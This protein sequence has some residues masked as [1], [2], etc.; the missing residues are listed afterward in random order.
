[1]NEISIELD[2]QEFAG[3]ETIAGAVIVRLDQDTPL[4]GI[5]LVLEGYE[6][7]SWREGGGRHRHTHSETRRLFD[8]DVTL[9]GRP[10]LGLGELLADSFKG[11]FSKDSYEV[12]HAGNYRYPFTYVLPP[13][14]PGDYE[15][16]LTNS[17][18]YY[19]VKVQVDLP[20]KFDL[21][22]EQPLAVREPTSA[23]AVQPITQRQTKKSLFDCDALIEAQVHLDKD[24][25]YP[26]EVLRCQLEVMNRAPKK[27]IRAAT[28]LLRLLETAYAGG[29]THTGPTEITRARF[30]DCD[31]PL[32]QCARISLK[33]GIPTDLYPTISRASLVRLDYELVVVLDIPWAVDAKISVP[34]KLVRRRSRPDDDN[35]SSPAGSQLFPTTNA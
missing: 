5:R 1:M 18:I 16:A 15:S 8:Q 29:R 26:G 22:A 10:R 3:G 35:T 32:N 30:A 13:Q 17:R 7:S 19:G 34:I 6:H 21:K 20:L 23:A 27:E 11:I 12:L 4:R 25:Y 33:L 2:K 9:H 14:L 24:T 28:L 31:F